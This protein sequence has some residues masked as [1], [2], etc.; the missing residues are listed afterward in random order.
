MGCRFGM[1]WINSRKLG[2]MGVIVDY[3]FVMKR[4]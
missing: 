1:G 3:N 2:L 4:L